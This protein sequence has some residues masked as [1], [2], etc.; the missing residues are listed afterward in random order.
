MPDDKPGDLKIV[1]LR[2]SVCRY[3]RSTGMYVYTDG[4][5]TQAKKDYDDT[6]FW[7]LK[8]MNNFGPDDELV[9]FE[10]C[11]DRAR[12]CHEPL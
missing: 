1:E 2:P 9:A 3:L 10:Q 12:G 7:C 6:T 4:P 8:T 5:D 11:R